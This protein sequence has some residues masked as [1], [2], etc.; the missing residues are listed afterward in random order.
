M[1]EGV[2]AVQAARVIKLTAKINSRYLFIAKSRICIFVCVTRDSPFCK[3]RH[4]LRR[5][6]MNEKEAGD[7]GNRNVQ[8]L[9]T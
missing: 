9:K 6:T 4:T 1:G 2:G 8:R 7:S 3:E 5:T